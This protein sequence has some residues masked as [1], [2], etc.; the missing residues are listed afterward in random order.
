M[1]RT[2]SQLL[3]R[4][5]RVLTVLFI[6]LAIC[7]HFANGQT[8]G[9]VTCRQCLEQPQDEYG[10]RKVLCQPQRAH[11]GDVSG[12]PHG[13]EIGDPCYEV[14]RY[15]A[16]GDTTADDSGSMLEPEPV[17]NVNKVGVGPHPPN[18][19][20]MM[21]EC[22]QCNLNRV[23]ICVWP[24]DCTQPG[25]Y[26]VDCT[27]DIEAEGA[28]F[29]SLRGQRFHI[30]KVLA[31]S[32]ESTALKIEGNVVKERVKCPAEC[33]AKLCPSYCPGGKGGECCV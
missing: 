23:P 32:D 10:R 33:S 14:C 20:E 31:P 4:H 28:R 13:N 21:V 11:N 3:L 9:A 18:Y 2:K 12:S 27:N 24:G 29:A 30:D 25:T 1:T 19:E 5:Q 7:S 8:A 16:G 22:V 6:L 17:N 26:I 15:A